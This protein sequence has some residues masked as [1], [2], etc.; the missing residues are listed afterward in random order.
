MPWTVEDVDAHKKGLTPK[1]K[2]AW[3]HIANDA[4]KRCLGDGRSQSECEGSAIRQANSAAVGKALESDELRL[5]VE[6]SI[7]KADDSQQRLFGWASIAVMKDGTPLLDLQG[8]VID[9]NDL[10]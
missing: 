3:V 8:D 9:I 2:R 5:V 4:L 7:A 10:E 1:E 6:A